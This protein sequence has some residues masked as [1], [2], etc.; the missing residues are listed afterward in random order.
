MFGVVDRLWVERV[1]QAVAQEVEGDHGH[2]DQQAQVD[3]ERLV[4]GWL[5]GA[6]LNHLRCPNLASAEPA[7]SPTILGSLLAPLVGKASHIFLAG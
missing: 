6:V 4:D 1:L 7:H 5:G 3:G 2:E